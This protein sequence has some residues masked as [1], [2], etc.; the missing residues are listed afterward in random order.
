MPLSEDEQRILQQIERQFYVDDPTLADEMQQTTLTSHCIRQMG[1]A[2]L[3][4]TA[5]TIV[6]VAVLVT[7]SPFPLAFAAFLVML[8][9]VLWF[10]H[11]FRKLGRAGTEELRRRFR[12]SGVRNALGQAG[13]RLRAPRGGRPDDEG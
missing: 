13:E 7:A 6:L 10:E 4:F 3:L 11:G 8:G 9:A 1:R 5:A 2:A 12:S